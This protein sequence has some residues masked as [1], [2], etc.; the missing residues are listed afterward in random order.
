MRECLQTYPSLR[1]N[2]DVLV[3]TAVATPDFAALLEPEHLIPFRDKHMG[4]V[5]TPDYRLVGL[6]LADRRIARR[7]AD[8]QDDAGLYS[9]SDA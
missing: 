9:R 2:S 7:A 4:T 1:Q 5:F 8:H 3:L 6:N